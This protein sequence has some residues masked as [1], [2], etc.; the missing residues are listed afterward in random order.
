VSAQLLSTLAQP[1]PLGWMYSEIKGRVQQVFPSN[2]FD[3]SM[4]PKNPDRKWFS[5][6]A[7]RTP[8]LA[9]GW[10]GVANEGEGA[11]FGGR[12][13]WTLAMVVKNSDVEARY[14]GDALSPGLFAMVRVATLALN[15]FLPNPPNTDWSAE[16]SIV[17]SA[18][19]NLFEGDWGDDEMAIAGLDLHCVYEE[20]LVPG[21]E[22]SPAASLV[23]DCGWKFGDATV[24]NATIGGA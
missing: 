19:G 24:L 22:Q 5:K 8:F 7:R 10:Q 15:G 14:M 4:M 9:L 6:Y 13:H 17:V 23:L 12:A 11:K 3:F 16:R 1:G 2:L 21:L 18:L 20:Q